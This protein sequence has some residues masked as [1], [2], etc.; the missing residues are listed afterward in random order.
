MPVADELYRSADLLV[1]ARTGCDSSYCVVTFDSFTDRRTLD[2]EGFGETFFASRGVNAIHVLSRDNDWYLLPDIE[3]ALAAAAKAAR[4]FER[5]SAYGSSMGAYAAIRLGGLAGATT[6]IALSPQFSLDPRLVPFEDRWDPDARR[7]DYEIERRLALK[8]FVSSADVFYDPTDRDARHVELY[9]ACLEARD[10]R[11]PEC[12]HP[13]TGFLAEVGL[14]Q[15]AVMEAAQGTLDRAAFERKALA[16][17]GRS[18]QYYATL[19]RRPGPPQKKLELARQAY[20]LFPNDFGYIAWYAQALS[21]AGRNDEA[22][23][24]FEEAMAIEPDHLTVLT[25]L[26]EFLASRRRLP[27][28]RAVADWLSR[29]HPGAA[30]IEAFRAELGRPRLA[31][32]PER[33]RQWRARLSG[34]RRARMTRP[35]P[36]LSP[37]RERPA[38]A[39]GA[40]AP[41][42]PASPPTIQSWMRHAATIAAVPR[43]PVDA[44]LLGDSLAHQ[45]PANAWSG[46]RVLNLGVSGDRTQHV[47]WRLACF[48]DGAIDAKAVVLMI[49]V[50]NLASGDKVQSIIEAIGDVIGEIRRVA[51]GAT[52]AV[53]SLPPFG[54]DFRLRDDDRK[55][56]NASLTGMADVTVVGEPALWAPRGTEAGCYQPDAVH[57][58]RAGYDRLSAATVR[59]LATR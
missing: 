1:R 13:V 4:P 57:F 20:E 55:A 53:V 26:C 15:H 33:L 10:V 40:S 38:A 49:G 29:L 39:T 56:L 42:V 59:A 44:V 37:R 46:R 9:R 45:W 5:V 16:M 25:R 35:H 30:P 34:F 47:L 52:I 23:A 2:R 48:D 41:R 24:K 8:G 54:P 51:P 18:P 19:A 28:A 31:D 50:N 17:R 6:A 58:T 21:A 11:L 7:L 32:A 43:S 3:L 22:I 36:T 14:L 12:G 27:A